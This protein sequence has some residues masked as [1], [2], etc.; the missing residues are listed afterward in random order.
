M[1]KTW[2]RR[3]GLQVIEPDSS[4]EVLVNPGMG[5]ETFHGFN[6]DD[7]NTRLKHYPRCSIAY[8]R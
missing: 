6:D 5:F 2:A 1:L 4:D 7:R 3:S 8:Y